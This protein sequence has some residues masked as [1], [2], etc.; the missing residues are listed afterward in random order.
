[1]LDDL[2]QLNERIYELYGRLYENEE[3]L[4]KKQTDYMADK[5]FEA[6]KQ[7]YG[8]LA[9]NA[10]P[11]T[12]GEAFA[13]KER[14]RLLVPY[15][16]GRFAR[17]FLRRRTN[18]VAKLILREVREAAERAFAER[19]AKL[20][21]AKKAGSRTGGGT[22]RRTDSARNGRRR[23]GRT[24]RRAAGTAV[25]RRAARAAAGGAKYGHRARTGHG[26]R[27]AERSGRARDGGGRAFNS[28]EQAERRAS[29]G[30]AE[31]RRRGGVERE[32]PARRGSCRLRGAR[33][34]GRNFII[35]SAF[36][37][38]IFLRMQNKFC[39]RDFFSE[40]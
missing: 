22:A 28:G 35:P 40:R 36:S 39:P 8:V 33:R 21:A 13:A 29:Q 23:D 30:Q 5:L 38:K 16:P 7:E 10:E 37:Y 20:D 14:R 17:I 24:A 26:T 32:L 3:L 34:R 1:M 18:A 31:R 11:E 6:Y 27:R 2:K 19:T 15:V 25:R 9:L 12:A 4:T